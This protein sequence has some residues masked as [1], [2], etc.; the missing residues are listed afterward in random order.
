MDLHEWMIADFASMR[1]KL[2]DSVLRLVRAERWHEQADGGGSTLAGLLLHIARH[3]DLAVNVV[4][5]NHEP[6]FAAHSAP[7]GLTHA[8]PG[9]GLAE[10]EDRTTTALV[11]PEAVLHYATDVFDATAAWLSPLG[12]MALD[13]EPNTAYRLTHRA[14][15]DA[16]KLPWLYSM[17]EGK[18]LWWFVQWPV[19]GHGH[20]HVGEAI[21]LRNRMGLSPF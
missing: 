14:G 20:A 9:V 21:S 11:S 8:G 17:W 7:L 3:Q 13:I 4:I 18:A 2:F 16:D 12:S 1:G 10:R 19:I 15:L 6:L 5:R